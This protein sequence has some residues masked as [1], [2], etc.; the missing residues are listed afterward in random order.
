MVK[1]SEKEVVIHSDGRVQPYKVDYGIVRSLAVSNQGVIIIGFDKVTHEDDETSLGFVQI[2]KTTKYFIGTIRKIKVELLDEKTWVSGYGTGVDIVPTGDKVI[3]G[4]PFEQKVYVYTLRADKTFPSLGDTVR[5]D[6][7]KSAFGSKVAIAS[8]GQSIAIADPLVQVDGKQVGAIYVYAFLE[9]VGWRGRVDT[10]F[11]RNHRDMRSLGIGSLVVD[12]VK[13][14][15]DARDLNDHIFSFVYNHKCRDVY[16]LPINSNRN[17]AFLPHCK[18][19]SGFRSFKG[20]PKNILQDEEDYCIFCLDES[21]DC[22]S[23]PT[24]SPT[25]APTVSNKPS[26]HPGS[27]A[28]PSSSPTLSRQ[29]SPNPSTSRPSLRPTTS[30][31]PTKTP[32]MQ[33]SSFGTIYDG[34]SCHFNDECASFSCVANSCQGKVRSYEKLFLSNFSFQFKV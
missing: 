22:G 16:S 34:E 30:K 19:M 3:V 27:T 33:P 8:D 9:G 12:S 7:S 4:S 1:S 15:V 25:A 11:G 17:N 2:L 31:N 28:F 24:I 20:H 14:R 21:L 26:F 6:D 23:R 32:S 13:G 5:H 10:L 18:C 29:P